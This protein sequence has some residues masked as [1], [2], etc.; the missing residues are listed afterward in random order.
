MLVCFDI[1]RTLLVG[2]V[3]EKALLSLREGCAKIQTPELAA[4]Q[5]APRGEGSQR[6]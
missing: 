1:R 6:A 3:L 5:Y 2:G 4:V